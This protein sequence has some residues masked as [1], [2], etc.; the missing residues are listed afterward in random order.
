MEAYRASVLHFLEDPDKTS[1]EKSYQYFEDGMLVVD[2]GKIVAA[3]LADDL[4]P[5]LA[6]D[7]TVVDYPNCLLM[8][9]FVDTHIHYPQTEMIAAYGEIYANHADAPDTAEAA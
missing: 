6:S 8:P 3:G 1:E 7:T 5:Y 4:I 2:G 9:G